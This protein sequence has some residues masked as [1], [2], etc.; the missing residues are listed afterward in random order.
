MSENHDMEFF[1]PTMQNL[2]WASLEP[3]IQIFLDEFEGREDWT[4]RYDEFPSLFVETARMLPRVIH[5]PL[6]REA[7]QI[8]HMLMPIL[9]SMP[10]RQCISAVA[11]LDTNSE[12]QAG[13]GWGMMCYMESSRIY[14]SMKDSPVYLHAK[15]LYERIRIMLHTSLS[16]KLFIN[17]H[18]T[19]MNKN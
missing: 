15:I 10:L 19:N 16:S 2:Y 4:Y 9:S 5:I 1:S 6:N 3:D 8:V 11:W 7:M 18:K 14:F 13:K 12:S 17:I